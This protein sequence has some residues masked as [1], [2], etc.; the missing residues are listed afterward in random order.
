MQYLAEVQKKS[1]GL[2][3]ASKAELRLI[4]CQR[5]EDNWQAMAGSNVISTDKASDYG[6]G[7][8]VI[9]EIA[10]NDVKRVSAA[11]QPVLK[12]LQ[13][14]SRLQE[15]LKDKDDDIEQWKQSLTYQSQEL[16]RRVMEVEVREEQLQQASEELARLEQQRQE[17]TV[18]REEI[19]RNQAEI[20]T[21]QQEIT[22]AWS[23]LETERHHLEHQLQTG[24]GGGS[25][26]PVQ[27]QSLAGQL[28]Q[29]EAAAPAVDEVQA[30]V[31]QLFEQVQQQQPILDQYWHQAEA[32]GSAADIDTSLPTLQQ[33]WA[34]WSEGQADLE[35]LRGEL[36]ALR[37]ELSVKSQAAETL[38]RQL[39]ANRL[40]KQQL[41]HL[42]GGLDPDIAAQ[43][44]FPALEQMSIEELESKVQDLQTDYKRIFNFVN[45]QEEELRFQLQAVDELKQKIA[46]A[47]EFDR[48]TL[49]TELA[50]EQ[51]SYRI[52]DESMFDQRRTLNERKTIL[53]QYESILAKRRGQSVPEAEPSIDL[54]PLLSQLAADTVQ[55]NQQLEDLKAQIQTLE[56]QQQDL[57]VRVNQQTAVQMQKRQD[58]DQL[59]RT[60]SV[61]GGGLGDTYR[62]VLHPV[63]EL[64]NQL[65]QQLEGLKGDCDRLQE[66]RHYQHQLLAGLQQTLAD[67]GGTVYSDAA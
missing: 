8:L 58:L 65:R 66:S 36:A 7:T 46:E 24:Q 45:D 12:I 60:L 27:L 34:A 43:I 51:D 33:A 30:R 25:L 54:G 64:V 48:L 21:K 20:E 47:S 56:A 52:L 2:L 39:K 23:Q 59:S 41:T 62:A 49:E 9:A 42:A 26:D 4:A 61:S 3:G 17:V 18:L 14:Y 63:Q 32:G 67:L 10:G 13:H 38:Q 35:R 16:N 31:A 5:S 28:H 22:A 57:E 29:L 55:Y 44:D 50:D 53:S 11:T 6:S 40:L 37:R 1:G 19:Q 15:K